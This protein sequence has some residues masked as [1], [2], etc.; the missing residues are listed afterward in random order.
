M[1][2]ALWVLTTAA[3]PLAYSWS[4]I[5]TAQGIQ[6]RKSSIYSVT[7]V[8]SAHICIREDMRKK[9]GSLSQV[10]FPERYIYYTRVDRGL[11]VVFTWWNVLWVT[12]SICQLSGL[13]F[14][15]L[16][17]WLLMILCLLGISFSWTD[18]LERRKEGALS[19]HLNMDQVFGYF[20]QRWIRRQNIQ[21]KLFLLLF[22]K[23]FWR[24]HFFTCQTQRLKNR[25]ITIV[26][27][28]LTDY[29]RRDCVAGF[30]TN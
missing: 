13:T 17:R 12:S 1:E 10:I 15:Q 27:L 7:A 22:E 28:S 26:I 2:F 6:R 9:H 4:Y 5:Q 16:Q 23:Q 25:D 29:I 11:S 30:T 18:I 14:P 24:Q 19:S 20:Q 3:L 8:L 21:K